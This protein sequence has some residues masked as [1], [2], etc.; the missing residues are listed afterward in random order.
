MTLLSD[1]VQGKYG[2]RYDS[3]SDCLRTH[4]RLDFLE[5]IFSDP[6]SYLSIYFFIVVHTV[7]LVLP[8][9]PFCEVVMVAQ[10]VISIFPC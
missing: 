8:L 5:Y 1:T 2:R 4:R 7:P 3:G 6:V 10:E 9:L